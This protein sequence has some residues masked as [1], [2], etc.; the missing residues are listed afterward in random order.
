VIHHGGAGTTASVLH[1]GIPHIVI[2][3]ISDQ[4]FFASE[5]RRLGVGL[6]VKRKRWPED[7]PNAVSQIENSDAMQARAN[8]VAIQLAEENGP[9]SAVRE[10]E[11]LAAKS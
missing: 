7:L 10:L 2:P 1:A 3:H 9:Q 5:V 6:E 11:L 8:E 4:W